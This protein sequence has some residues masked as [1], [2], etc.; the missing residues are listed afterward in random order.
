MIETKLQP[1]RA[2][3]SRKYVIAMLLGSIGAL[4]A[5][6]AMVSSVGAAGNCRPVILQARGEYDGQAYEVHAQACYEGSGYRL[7]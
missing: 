7:R 1:W 3:V 6:F 4:I 2:L 5:V